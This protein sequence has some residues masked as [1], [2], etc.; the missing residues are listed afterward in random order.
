MIIQELRQHIRVAHVQG[1]FTNQP[2]QQSPPLLARANQDWTAKFSA[3]GAIGKV[4]RVLGHAHLA[5]KGCYCCF[6]KLFDV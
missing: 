6:Q 1:G 5:F 2:S 3:N 4:Q